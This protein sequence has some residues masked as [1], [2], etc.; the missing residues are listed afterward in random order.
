[1]KL[2]ILLPI[3]MAA[4]GCHAQWSHYGADAGGSRYSPLRQ[5]NRET[6]AN[7]E[8]AWTYHTGALEPKS[9]L[10]G[11]AASESTPILAAG[12]LIVTTPFNHVIALDPAT[13]TERWKYDPGIDRTRGYSEV[14]NRG[15]ASWGASDGSTRIF[16]GTIDSRLIALDGATGKPV[17]GFGDHGIVDLSSGV[18]VVDRG[19]YQMTSPPTV[20]GDTVVVGSS[21]GDNRRVNLE[22]GVV[23]GYDA[24]TGKQLW[25]WDPI[26]WAQGQELKTGAA[27]AWSVLSADPERDL[28]FIPT[29]SASPDFF[30]GMRPGDNRWANSVVALKASTGEFVWG[31]QAV[32]HDL[33]D[34]DIAAQPSLFLF[35][36][37]TP[38]IAVATKSGY[39]YVLDRLTGEPLLPVTETAVPKSDVPGEL[40]HP[41][42]PIPAAESLLPLTVSEKD[43]WGATAADLAWC[44]EKFATL[45]YEGPF[46]PPSLGASLQYPGNVGG[47]N[48]GSAAVSPNGEIVVTNVNHLGFIVRLIPQEK[49][50]EERKA[51]ADN[52]L[53]GE[54][55][56]QRGSAYAMYREPFLTPGRLP[57]FAPPWGTVVATNANTGKRLWAVPLGQFAPNVPEGSLNLGGPI[58]TAG[59]LVFTA[60][61]V[62]PT[63][64]AFDSGSGRVLWQ[65][66]L[67][68]SAQATPMTYELDGRQFVVIS[69][70]GHGKLRTK[71][72]DAVVAFALPK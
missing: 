43:L 65:A 68:A 24:V 19:D 37:K 32:H 46:T 18:G 28:V 1:M 30:G 2:P 67:P 4:F 52:R 35:Q 31:F 64:R 58:L 29:G 34:F 69:A 66:I 49:L 10:N 23:R 60:A 25:S 22:S 72:G 15:V 26:P 16:L 51:A 59:G 9:E 12:S 38:A 27:N 6:V 21:I 71:Q 63:L 33:W 36:G 3:L 50:G 44:R 40:A 53:T 41:T 13:G 62:D 56:P 45:R 57:C 61:A 48:W 8:V 39:L 42:Q 5:I 17:E 47:V 54:F 14:T 55:G 7:L 20:V 70:G 11:K